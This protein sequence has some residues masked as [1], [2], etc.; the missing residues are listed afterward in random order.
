MF[1][2]FGI[3]TLQW[4]LILVNFK[5][6]EDFLLRVGIEKDIIGSIWNICGVIVVSCFT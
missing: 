5:N 3:Y 4:T 2:L 6:S 1:N